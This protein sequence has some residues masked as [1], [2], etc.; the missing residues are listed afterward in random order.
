MVLVGRPASGKS[1]LRTQYFTPHNYEAVNRDTLGTKE[2]CVK[3]TSQALKSGRSV[4]VDNTNPSK[5]DRQLYVDLAKKTGVPARCIFLNIDTA[6][7]YHL[8]MFR[9]NQSHG[10]RRRVPEV[11]YRTYE[12]NFEKPDPSEGFS[13]IIELDFVPQFDSDSDKKLFSQWTSMS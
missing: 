9:Q 2:K 10:E 1:T 8:N 4:V 7:A 6:L 12:K 13:E 3:A 11:A 5:A